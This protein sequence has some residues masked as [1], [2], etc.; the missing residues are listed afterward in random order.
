MILFT[1]DVLHT[2]KLILAYNKCGNQFRQDFKQDEETEDPI[3]DKSEHRLHLHHLLYLRSLSN[4]AAFH[5]TLQ[6]A[7]RKKK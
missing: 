3:K 2:N 6:V 4:R 5:K 1:E 7:G